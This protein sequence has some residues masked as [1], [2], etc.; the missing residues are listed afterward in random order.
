M[1]E[2]KAREWQKKG[3]ENGRKKGG[4]LSPSLF[5]VSFMQVPGGYSWLIPQLGDPHR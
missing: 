3:H 1:T 5:L 2:K 4:N